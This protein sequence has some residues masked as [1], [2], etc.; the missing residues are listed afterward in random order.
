LLVS[1]LNFKIYTTN[2]TGTIL[3]YRPTKPEIR[4]TKPSVPFAKLNDIG[5]RLVLIPF[6]GIAIPLIT[7]MYRGLDL[8]HWMYKLSFA[9]SIGMSFVIWHGNR[10]LLFT[11]RSYFNWLN[12]PVRKILALLL[13]VSFFTIPVT[14]LLLVGWYRLF[15][16]GQVDREVLFNTTLLIMICVLFITHVYETVF[17]VKESESEIVRIEQLEKARAQAELEALKSQIDPHFIFNSLNT[18]SHLIENDPARARLYNDTMADVFRYILRNKSRNLVLL[19]EEFDFLKGY[20][21]LLQIRFENAVHLKVSFS[22][23]FLDQFLIPPISMQVL[24]ENA[25]KHNGFS[26][27]TPLVIEL[28]LGEDELIVQNEKRPKPL[29]KPSSGIGLQNLD[30]RCKLITEKP[31]RILSTAETFQVGVPILK[32]S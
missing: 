25:I 27:E 13:A 21:L 7:R 17:L 10:F 16:E 31:I 4:P 6:F 9:Y 12:Q 3:E 14:V 23:A 30:E 8:G 24:V 5:F 22:E 28:G 32:L 26:D 15:A 1:K 29:R 19:R 11:L 20:F 18:L 2:P